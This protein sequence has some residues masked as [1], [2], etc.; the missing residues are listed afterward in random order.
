MRI[1]LTLNG[2]VSN[3]DEERTSETLLHTD[4]GSSNEHMLVSTA[5][6]GVFGGEITPMFFINHTGELSSTGHRGHLSSPALMQLLTINRQALLQTLPSSTLPLQFDDV[7][8]KFSFSAA[9]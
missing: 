3:P 9:A 7:F 1:L 2:C 4:T 6:S 5:S 8:G